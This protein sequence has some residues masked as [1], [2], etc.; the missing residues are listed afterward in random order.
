MK[1]R[2]YHE[3][4][5]E[6]FE[7]LSQKIETGILF[8]INTK[9]LEKCNKFRAMTGGSCHNCPMIDECKK[10]TKINEDIINFFKGQ[11]QKSTSPTKK[12]MLKII[13]ILTEEPKG[14]KKGKDNG[15]EY[16]TGKGNQN[17]KRRAGSSRNP[18]DKAH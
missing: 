8:A 1:C 11:I 12:Q 18:F 9:H 5:K 7:A 13:D 14:D 4:L 15:G 2:C 10:I 17:S 6:E 16:D 3:H